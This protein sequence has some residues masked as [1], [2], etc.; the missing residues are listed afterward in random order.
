MTEEFWQQWKKKKELSG[1][2]PMLAGVSDCIDEVVG[3]AWRS[4]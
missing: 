1:E 4:V 3:F 2:N